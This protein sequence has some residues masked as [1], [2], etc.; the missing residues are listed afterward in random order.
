MPSHGPIIMISESKAIIFS[1]LAF[2][3]VIV[4]CACVRVKTKCWVVLIIKR[5]KKDLDNFFKGVSN[6]WKKLKILNGF[7]SCQ[8]S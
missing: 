4:S 7:Q 8:F 3:E 1:L 6:F 5:R 2:L